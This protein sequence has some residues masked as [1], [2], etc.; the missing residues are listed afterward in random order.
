MLGNV[1]AL[2]TKI[3][4]RQGGKFARR[5]GKTDLV[6]KQHL[7]G[8]PIRIVGSRELPKKLCV[9]PTGGAFN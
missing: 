6:R 7:G 8:L 5:S 3:D 1:T 9:L 2:K 4:Y